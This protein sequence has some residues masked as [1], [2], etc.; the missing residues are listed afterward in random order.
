[1]YRLT[2]EPS[3]SVDGSTNSNDDAHLAKGFDILTLSLSVSYAFFHESSF[4][5]TKKSCPAGGTVRTAKPVVP[6]IEITKE[7]V[8]DSPNEEAVKS[9]VD[10]ILL[11][12]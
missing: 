9:L 6:V 1:M 3:F 11:K 7:D 10:D 8:S 5:Q 2:T 12:L 4:S